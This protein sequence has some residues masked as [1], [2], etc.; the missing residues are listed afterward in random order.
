MKPKLK[1]IHEQAIVLF[2][3]TSGIGLET[4]MHMVEKGASVAI[5][6]RSQEGLNDAVQ[7]V[8]E[9]AQASQMA[10]GH[11]TNGSR[12]QTYGNLESAA[13]EEMSATTSTTEMDEQVIAIE[14][15][16]TNWEQ[17]RSAAEQVVQNFGR[18]D[19]WVNL[20]AVS[21][22]ALFED[23]SPDEFSRI[24]QVNLV[25][26]AYGAMAAL[27]YLKQ[28]QGG[29]L[30]FVS[31][32]AGKV[33]I[34]YQSAYNASKHGIIGLVET[35]RQEVIH[36]G[37]PVNVV[38]IIPSSV[39]TPLFS[40]A[41]T[42]LGVE[43][44]PIPP[45]YDS[46]LVAKAIIHA[47]AHPVRE[48]IV[49]DAGYMMTFM[50][51]LAPTLTSNYMGSSGF[52]KQRSNEVKSA[53]APDNLYE[54]LSGYNQV[55]GEYTP[56]TKRFSP[57]TWLS[58]HDNV[59]LGLIA[60]LISGLGFLVGSRI[61][62]SRAQ[63]RRSM[64][65]RVSQFGRDAAAFLTALP[66][67]SSLPMFRHRSILQR[68]GDALP[69]TGKKSFKDR[70]TMKNQRQKIAEKLPSRK[71]LRRAAEKLPSGKDLRRVAEKLPMI[72]RRET[73]V[74][75]LPFRERRESLIEKMP[76]KK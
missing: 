12:Y 26:H 65:Y 2:G 54:H 55:E 70:I 16:V 46:S 18:I 49:G 58:T 3:A 11:S 42:K 31:S 63:R 53:Q 75:K 71:D 51:R 61:V 21:E 45:I 5:V 67:I 23:T 76:F 10:R 36:T 13:A 40:K 38:A 72:E 50:R 74:E 43:P 32:V 48:L 69:F 19:T 4:A 62:L 37:L 33:P 41:R 39:N 60:G 66:L 6:G 9:H 28:Q 22:W 24:I 57:I 47:S 14:A 59:R 64:G 56:R 17:V 44:E 30:I 27:P 73:F 1:P 68:F 29:S 34:P 35:L 52:R 15:D 7:R 8:R 25:G 20:A